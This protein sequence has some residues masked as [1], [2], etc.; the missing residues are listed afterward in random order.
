LYAFLQ[1]YGLHE[2]LHAFVRFM[3]QFLMKV[4]I[5]VF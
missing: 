1:C 3:G 4:R 2:Q 5:S